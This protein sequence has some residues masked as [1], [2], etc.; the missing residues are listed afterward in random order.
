MK[1]STQRG[2]VWRGTVCWGLTLASDATG[3]KIGHRSLMRYYKQRFGRQR[4]L[5]PVHNQRA[6]GR[7]LRQYRALGWAGESGEKLIIIIIFVGPTN[8][9]SLFLAYFLALTNY[10]ASRTTKLHPPFLYR[11]NSQVVVINPLLPGL[12]DYFPITACSSV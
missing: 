1:K 6:V 5:V 7:V 9:H 10:K 3:A 2:E 4:E 11:N 12:P 8:Q